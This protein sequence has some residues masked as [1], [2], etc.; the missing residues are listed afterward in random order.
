MLWDKAHSV[1]LMGRPQEP[2]IINCMKYRLLILLLFI[3]AGSQTSG[4]IL[5]HVLE[6]GSGTVELRVLQGEAWW[7]RYVRSQ[8]VLVCS[9]KRR[10]EEGWKRERKGRKNKEMH[11]GNEKTRRKKGRY[12]LIKLE[13]NKETCR[14]S[15]KWKKWKSKEDVYEASEK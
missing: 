1:R 8:I 13:R 12:K 11:E 14:T 2:Y 15:K 9:W 3:M 6:R 4:C 10:K 7:L 5:K